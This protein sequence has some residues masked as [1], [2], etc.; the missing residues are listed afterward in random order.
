MALVL[1]ELHAFEHL[2][3]PVLDHAEHV[4]YHA[5][6]VR[7]LANRQIVALALRH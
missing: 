1:A 5:D 2:R 6:T 3:T 4:L 7:E